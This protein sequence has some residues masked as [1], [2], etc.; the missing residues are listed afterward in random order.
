MIN[1]Y[2]TRGFS[3]TDVHGDNEFYME[4]LRDSIKLATLHIYGAEEHVGSIERAVR[5]VKDRC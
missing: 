1:T 3:I 4:D 5:T 2:K